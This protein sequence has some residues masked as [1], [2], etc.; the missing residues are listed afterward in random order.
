MKIDE[1]AARELL[2]D[3]DHGVLSTAHT[4]R[5][6][7]AVPVVFALH[8]GHL[9]VPVDRVKPKAG[10]RL[11]RERNLELDPRAALLVDHWDAEDWSALWWVRAELRWD[12][13]PPA[14]LAT[15]LAERLAR[16]HRQYADRPFDRLLVFEV[17]AVTGWTAS[18]RPTPGS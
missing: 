18:E 12:S 15:E 4:S 11:Q 6:V 14:E 9:A 1:V 10:G 3:A 16:K 5:G 7:D 13:A 17:H 2:T 8:D